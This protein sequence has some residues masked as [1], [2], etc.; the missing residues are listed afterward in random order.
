MAAAGCLAQAASLTAANAL[1]LGNGL[2]PGVDVLVVLR[3]YGI[4]EDL[5]GRREPGLGFRL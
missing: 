3:H 1:K 2:E 4:P 5:R